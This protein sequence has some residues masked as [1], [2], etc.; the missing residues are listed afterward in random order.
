MIYLKLHL[1]YSVTFSTRNGE[2][3]ELPPAA[4]T[5]WGGQKIGKDHGLG[6]KR[7]G[8]KWNFPQ[9]TNKG[10]PSHPHLDIEMRTKTHNQYARDPQKDMFCLDSKIFKSQLVFQKFC[11]ALRVQ[12]KVSF[13]A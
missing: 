9:M 2:R 8:Q 4:L 1:I 6:V 13:Y 11:F 7:G 12:I 3:F 5:A 10:Q